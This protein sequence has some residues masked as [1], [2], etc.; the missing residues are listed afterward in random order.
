MAQFQNSGHSTGSV[1]RLPESRRIG[2]AAR[3]VDQASPFPVKRPARTRMQG[4][5]GA[6]G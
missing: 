3:W 2:I 1:E 5:V 6:E 4:V